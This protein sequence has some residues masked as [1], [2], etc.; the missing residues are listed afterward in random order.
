MLPV[1]WARSITSDNTLLSRSVS[2]SD[3]APSERYTLYALGA[4]TK[5][6]QDVP[7]RAGPNPARATR[8]G[9]AGTDQPSRT[10]Q[11]GAR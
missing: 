5:T 10:S 9:P 8:R 11:T 4:D 7:S 3:V 1:R 2:H 6:S